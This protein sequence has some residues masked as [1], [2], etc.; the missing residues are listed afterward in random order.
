M[1]LTRTPLR[2]KTSWWSRLAARSLLKMYAAAALTHGKL[3]TAFATWQ[4]VGDYPHRTGRCCTRHYRNYRCRLDLILEM[5]CGKE[6][7]SAAW[8]HHLIL[9]SPSVPIYP[10]TAV[11]LVRL[12]PPLFPGSAYYSLKHRAERHAAAV[13]I[14][15]R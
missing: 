6:T 2:L 15:C 9:S 5:G 1:R 11:P 10:L 14:C 4:D 12:L 3:G 7:T 13:L 8:Y